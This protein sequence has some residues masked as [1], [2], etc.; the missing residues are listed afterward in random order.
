MKCPCCG[1]ESSWIYNPSAGGIVHCNSC[2]NNKAEMS[3][4]K[5]LDNINRHGAASKNTVP[6]ANTA[7]IAIDALDTLGL[8]LAEHH[9]Q[10]TYDERVKYDK[11]IRLLFEAISLPSGH[12][13]TQPAICSRAPGLCASQRIDVIRC[14]YGGDCPSKQPAGA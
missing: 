10:F 8:A 1:S 9:H 13:H 11:A 12:Q 3:V 4:S 2:G 14:I 7:E 6:Q 5:F